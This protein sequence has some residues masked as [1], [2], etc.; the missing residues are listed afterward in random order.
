MGETLTA[1]TSGISDSNGLSNVQ[2]AHQWIRTSGGTD[3]D[4]SGATGSTYALTDDDLGKT[5]KVRVSFTDDDG[6]LETLTSSATSAVVQPPSQAASGQPTITGTAEVGEVLT[7]DTSGIADGNG[8]S[9]PQYTHQWVHSV[10]GTDTDISGATGSTYTPTSA[11]AG[12]AFKVRVSFTDDDG[13]SETLDQPGH[14]HPS[15]DPAAGRNL[16]RF[17]AGRRGFPSE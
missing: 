12:N 11:D 3:T 4:I 14:G 13:Y 9:N 16:Q 8:L 17:R 15:G 1:G 10:G 7:A 5:V 2:Y 6:Y